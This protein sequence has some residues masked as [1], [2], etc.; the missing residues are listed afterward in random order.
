MERTNASLFSVLSLKT[1]EAIKV[2]AIEVLTWENVSDS[3][4]AVAE[5]LINAVDNEC[6]YRISWAQDVQIALA[7]TGTLTGAF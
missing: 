7:A 1:L 3:Q 2:E 6:N 5:T 4:L